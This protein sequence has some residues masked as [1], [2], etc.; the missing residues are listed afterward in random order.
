MTINSDLG[1]REREKT[2]QRDG[3]RLIVI[4]GESASHNGNNEEKKKGEA[5]FRARRI[6]DYGLLNGLWNIWLKD[7]RQN[8]LNEHVL[9]INV[10][11]A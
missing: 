8:I 2:N 1:E 11:C 3:W 6:R 9:D 10:E 7:I 5:N 4:K